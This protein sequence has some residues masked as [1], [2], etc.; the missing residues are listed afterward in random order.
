MGNPAGPHRGGRPTDLTLDLAERLAGHIRDG[1]TLRCA[2]ALEMVPWGTFTQW[3]EKGRQGH[4]PYVVFADLTDQAKAIA[5][6]DCV[7]RI[8]KA[9]EGCGPGDW[10][11]DAWRLERRY[12]A[13][14]FLR[15]DR[16]GEESKLPDAELVEVLTEQ[17]EL[18]KARIAAK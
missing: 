13:D 2:A 11:A 1:N 16:P 10:K 18:A 15:P 8:R 12:R 6:A 9:G 3:L 4:E 7:G 5:E 14:W 17:L